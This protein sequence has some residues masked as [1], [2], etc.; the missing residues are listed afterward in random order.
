MVASI[1]SGFDKL[2]RCS[3]W[4]LPSAIA[5]DPCVGCRNPACATAVTDQRRREHSRAVAAGAE[6]SIVR[7]SRKGVRQPWISLDAFVE[8]EVLQAQV[9]HD[10]FRNP[11]SVTWPR[12]DFVRD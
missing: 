4:P 12:V 6:L 11:A 3:A 2:R 1:L 10:A 9:G 5:V 8:G 7:S